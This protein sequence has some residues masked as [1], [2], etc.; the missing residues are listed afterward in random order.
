MSD[1][2]SKLKKKKN[3]TSIK[4]WLCHQC[5]NHVYIKSKEIDERTN[6]GRF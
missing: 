1:P 6:G 3:T 2:N 5:I 4:N